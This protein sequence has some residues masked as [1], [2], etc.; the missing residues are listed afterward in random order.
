MTVSDPKDSAVGPGRGFPETGP[1]VSYYG[2][3]D[4]IDD[5]DQ[6]ADT[7]RII[8]IDADP[9]GQKITAQKITAVRTLPPN[10]STGSKQMA[11]TGSSAILTWGRWNAGALTGRWSQLRLNWATMLATQT[12]N[13]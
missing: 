4:D 3:A 13:G 1:W 2:S 12:K 6:V 10:R 7:F 11:A 9:D 8:N 5:F